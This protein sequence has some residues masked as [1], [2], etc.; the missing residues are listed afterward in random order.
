MKKIFSAVFLALFFAAL[1]FAAKSGPGRLYPHIP[2]KSAVWKSKT[3]VKSP[4]ETIKF[5]QTTYFKANKMRTEGVYMNPATKKKE[6][7]IVIIADN[8]IY[9]VNPDTKQGVKYSLNSKNNPQQAEQAFSECR[10]SGK[11]TG[12]ETL[13]SVKCDV[14]EYSCSVSGRKVK[15]KEWRAKDGFIMR[16][17]SIME[18]MTTTADIYDLKPNANVPDS[19]FVPDPGI[20]F[21]D[22][23]KMMGNN[24]TQMMKEAKKAKDE[25]EDGDGDGDEPDEAGQKMMKDMM[26]NM[27]GE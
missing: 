25:D 6:N 2:Y 10:Q 18:N 3:T 17:M 8:V 11:K 27:M 24:M 13:N 4:E 20:K 12:S 7:Q 21:M 9:M 19:K 5:D 14:Y 15:V 26:K 16:S 22:M 23:E 1:V